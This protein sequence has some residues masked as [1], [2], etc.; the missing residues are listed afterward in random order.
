[1]SARDYRA[2]ARAV[3]AAAR[4]QLNAMRA[5]RRAR[6]APAA[7]AGPA[8]AAETPRDS[9][10]DAGADLST[11]TVSRDAQSMAAGAAASAPAVAEPDVLAPPASVVEA[12]E[13][14]ANPDAAETA[15]PLEPAPAPA[16]KPS[17]LSELPG[18]GPGLVW[19]LQEAGC[20]SK[21]D[22]AAAD[23]EALAERLGVAGRLIDLPS[24]KRLAAGA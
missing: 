7:E 23:A 12:A 24:L 11:M 4:D 15:P 22:L 1:M 19:L 10:P 9:A 21:A 14:A 16:A 13:R 2:E 18:V 3:R 5:A 17:D 6:R 8:P 20:A